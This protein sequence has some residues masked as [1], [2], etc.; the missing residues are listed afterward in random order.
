MT[1]HYVRPNGT[2]VGGYSEESGDVPAATPSE[3]DAYP[4]LVENLICIEHECPEY[5]DQIW[6]FPGWSESEGKKIRRES[7]WRS[8][9]MTSIA[10]Q[11]LRLED[12]DPTS[13]PGSESEWREYRI[14]VRAWSEVASGYPDE[15]KRPRRPGTTK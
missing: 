4:E 8:S 1:I 3:N 10:D 5:A 7:F 14:K 11:L 12:S 9:E 13:L 15:N 2:Y 6:N